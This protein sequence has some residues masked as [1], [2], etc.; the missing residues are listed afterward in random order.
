MAEIAFVW[1]AALRRLS[2]GLPKPLG[3]RAADGIVS[4]RRSKCLNPEYFGAT[5]PYQTGDPRYPLPSAH[6]HSGGTPSTGY[7]CAEPNTNTFDI[8]GDDACLQFGGGTLGHPWGNAP[9]AV[10]NRVALE[11]CSQLGRSVSPRSWRAST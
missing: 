7:R 10:A 5:T 2:Q 1:Q 9:G 8:F 6:L 3:V 4:T 11:A